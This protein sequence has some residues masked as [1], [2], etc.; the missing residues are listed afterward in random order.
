MECVLIK[1]SVKGQGVAPEQI[2]EVEKNKQKPQTPKH[3]T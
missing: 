2:L 1:D 3:K